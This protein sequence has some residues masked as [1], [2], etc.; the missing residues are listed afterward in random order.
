MSLRRQGPW[1]DSVLAARREEMKFEEACA[2][3]GILEGQFCHSKATHLFIETLPESQYH[4]Y[5]LTPEPSK[6][7]NK[8]RQEQS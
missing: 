8:A 5:A 6:D 3:V 2:S 7:K 1:Q 4:P